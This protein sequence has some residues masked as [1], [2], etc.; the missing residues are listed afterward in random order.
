VDVDTFEG[1]VEG[2]ISRIRGWQEKHGTEL[3]IDIRLNRSYGGEYDFD[4]K[5]LCTREETD[6]EY[7]SRLE[8]AVKQK[9]TNAKRAKTRKATQ[10]TKERAKLRELATKYPEELK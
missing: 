3:F 2:L 5:L 6:K 1:S 8:Q 10:E 7:A 4:A 9:L